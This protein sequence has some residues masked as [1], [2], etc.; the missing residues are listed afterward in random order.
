[1]LIQSKCKMAKITL[2]RVTASVRGSCSIVSR[3]CNYLQTACASTSDVP[4]LFATIIDGG[5]NY[6]L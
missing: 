6:N 1:M 3:A 4:I 5:M 2:I